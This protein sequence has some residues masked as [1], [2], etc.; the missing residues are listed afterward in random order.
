MIKHPMKTIE[1]QKLIIRTKAIHK[2]MHSIYFIMITKIIIKL[3]S[4]LLHSL[5][6]MHMTSNKSKMMMIKLGIFQ[7]LYLI[8]IHLYSK[9]YTNMMKETIQ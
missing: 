6:E 2:T 1:I 5:E 7:T 3:K 8:Y 4:K 9:V